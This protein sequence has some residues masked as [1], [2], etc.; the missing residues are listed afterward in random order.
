ML[1]NVWVANNDGEEE[2]LQSFQSE[3]AA[4]NYAFDMKEE[5][6]DVWVSTDEEEDAD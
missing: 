1:Y 3:D 5:Y 2:F 4:Y 6:I